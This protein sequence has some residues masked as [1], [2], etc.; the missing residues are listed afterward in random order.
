VKASKTDYVHR[1]LVNATGRLFDKRD[2]SLF[3]AEEIFAELS[4]AEE[5]SQKNRDECGNFEWQFSEKKWDSKFFYPYLDKHIAEVEKKLTAKYS[6]PSM[7]RWPQ[8]HLFAL[9]I[10]HDVDLVSKYTKLWQVLRRI[11]RLFRSNPPKPPKKDL[12]MQVLADLSNFR[13]NHTSDPL[14]RYHE[15]MEI[16]E[17]LGFKSTFYIFPETLQKPHYCDC[18]YKYSDKIRFRNSIMTVAEMLKEISTRGWEIGLHGSYFSALD[19]GI[20]ASEKKHLEE[21]VGQEIISTRQHY[22]HYDIYH[23]TAIHNNAGFKTD[24]TIGYNRSVGFRCGTGLPFYTWDNV[25][26]K[27]TRV[28]EIPQVIMDGGL[29]FRNSLGYNKELAIEH[30]LK[31]MDQVEMTG[32][33]LTINWHP[34]YIVLP[35]WVDVF[36]AILEEAKRRHAWGT[37]AGEIY[38]WWKEREASLF[39]QST[40][41]L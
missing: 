27:E 7:A 16:E 38:R 24:S 31:V 14:W 41:H 36:Q 12:V 29:F 17:R 1:F 35:D 5:I 37:S 40:V 2:L 33:C 13:F 10:T 34:N 26:G 11:N 21:V 23:T 3:N 18:N 19:E 4:R 20:L 25:S 8:N 39:S 9:C 6:T 30:C 15:W 28:L 32:S 22:L